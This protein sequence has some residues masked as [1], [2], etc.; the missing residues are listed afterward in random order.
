MRAAYR[1]ATIVDY[2][3]RAAVVVMAFELEDIQERAVALEQQW[4]ASAA[5][6]AAPQEVTRTT[7]MSTSCRNLLM[8]FISESV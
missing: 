6:A 8:L 4:R 1:S 5:A 2:A 3:R 7:T